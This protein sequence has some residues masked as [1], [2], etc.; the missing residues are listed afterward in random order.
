MAGMGA[1]SVGRH[2]P[3]CPEGAGA[4]SWA[5]WVPTP[6][7]SAASGG[8]HGLTLPMQRNQGTSADRMWGAALSR[9][10]GTRRQEMGRG[11]VALTTQP[12]LP[13]GTTRSSPPPLPAT[14]G[15]KGAH[16]LCPH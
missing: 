15:Q 11:E 1:Q 3:V 12:C 14:S 10:Q 16:R 6:S 2:S 9:P 13:R 8:A 4:G 7:G 5:L